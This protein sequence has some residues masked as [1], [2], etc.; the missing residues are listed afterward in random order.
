MEQKKKWDKF[1]AENAD[2]RVFQ[3]RVRMEFASFT[4]LHSIL[5]L[6]LYCEIT[7]CPIKPVISEVVLFSALCHFAGGSYTDIL[8][9]CGVPK[10]SF[11]EILRSAIRSINEVDKLK[12]KF[13][14]T[15]G[16]C[17]AAARGFQSISKNEAIDSCVCVVGGYHLEIEKPSANDISADPYAFF[18]D[19]YDSYGVN[20]QAASDHQSRFLFLGVGGPGKREDNDALVECPLGD[21]IENLPGDFCAISDCGYRPSEHLIPLFPEDQVKNPT[22]KA[23]NYYA[24]ECQIRIEQA[25]G[26]LVQRWTIL[27]KPLRCKPTEVWRLVECVARLH[28]FCINERILKGKAATS[29]FEQSPFDYKLQKSLNRDRL[30]ARIAGKGLKHPLDGKQR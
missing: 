6:P 10:S 12:I 25:F 20:I 26:L 3:T 18:S 30:V 5:F 15:K 17:L 29:K 21:L 16:Q 11:K 22:R 9:L 2:A 14:K 7:S 8:D 24:S 23:F 28:N 4:K 1:V 19:H 27:Q 13:P